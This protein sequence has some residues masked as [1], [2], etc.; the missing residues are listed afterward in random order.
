MLATTKGPLVSS[1]I[2]GDPHGVIMDLSLTKVVD[3]DLC[4]V[5]RRL[6]PA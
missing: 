6:Q 1:D 5:Y 4:T 3:G 2:I